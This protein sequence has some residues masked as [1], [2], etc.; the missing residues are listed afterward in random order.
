MRH[1]TTL[2]V[3]IGL[4]FYSTFSFVSTGHAISK[5]L[6]ELAYHLAQ[7]YQTCA[8]LNELT[9]SEYFSPGDATEIYNNLSVTSQLVFKISANENIYISDIEE[10]A[11]FFSKKRAGALSKK[12]QNRK[13]HFPLIHLEMMF[14]KWPSSNQYR[15]NHYQNIHNVNPNLLLLVPADL[16][17]P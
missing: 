15:P 14:P 5:E 3:G 1:R 10:K 16:W 8:D 4:I 2:S 11:L 7:F 9:N 13:F 6:K 17:T 12:H